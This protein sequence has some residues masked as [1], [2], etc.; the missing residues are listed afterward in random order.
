MSPFHGLRFLYL[1][2]QLVPEGCPG[3]AM[4]Y[5]GAQKRTFQIASHFSRRNAHVYFGSDDDPSDQIVC[6]LEENGVRH[7]SIPFR[8]SV[9]FGFHRSIWKLLS[10]VKRNRIDL[11]HCNDRWTAMFSSFVSKLLKVP[12]I[13]NARSIYLDKRI[14]GR[15][16]GKNIIT[17]SSAVRKNLVDYFGISPKRIEVI[18]SGTD[19][20][21]STALEQE[22]VKNRFANNG[23]HRIVAVIA[24]LTEAKGHEYL[25]RALPKVVEK[26]PDIKLLFT[27]DGKLKQ[28]LQEKAADLG[29]AG[30]IVFCGYQNNVASFIDISVFTI[31]PSLWEGLPGSILESLLLAKPV[32]ASSV[33]GIP[34]VITDGVNGI[35]V[36]PRDVD[37]L[38]RSILFLLSNSRKRA[39]MGRN[40]ELIARRQFSLDRM[41]KQYENYY[42]RLLSIC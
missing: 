32:I 11:I 37:G 3:D 13:Y 1:Y 29:V 14:T 30:N 38:S 8:S 40:G 31:L 7:I 41:F 4:F 23:T 6:R 19:I 5:G 35:L 9:C 24:Q 22:E 10:T 27:G 42:S 18:Y 12:M 17:V 33:G 25:I 16:F 2:S 39:E 21:H 26:Y 28:S 15:F 34:E 36:E 20:I